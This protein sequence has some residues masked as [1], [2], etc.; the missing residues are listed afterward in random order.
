MA[1]VKER[2]IKQETG[3]LPVAPSTQAVAKKQQKAKRKERKSKD[4]TAD[5]HPEGSETPAAVSQ[6]DM[7]RVK[8]RLIKQE[9]GA[10][11]VPPSTQAVAEKQQKAKRKERK[12]KDH[13][14]DEHP[15][16][17]ETP[18]AVS[19]VAT[20][21]SEPQGADEDVFMLDTQPT[22]VDLEALAAARLR[23]EQAAAEKAKLEAPGLNRAARRRL[24][25]IARQ[26][27]KIIKELGLGPD[28][29]EGMEEVEAQVAEWTEQ[30]DKKT[31]VRLAKKKER[32][33]KDEARLRNRRGKLLKGR[34]LKEREKELKEIEKKR[35]R[36]ERKAISGV[37]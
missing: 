20:T 29:T 13:T 28:S 15:E 25:L 21:V 7:A 19:Q 23:A 24:K 6:V 26:R 4:N 30:L 35:A 34:R 22:P 9:T 16:G 11:P 27:E 8:E 33:A 36:Q 1:R 32:K 5:E 18:A 12:S 10:S 2:L 14:A 31:E 3:A 17:S 37:E